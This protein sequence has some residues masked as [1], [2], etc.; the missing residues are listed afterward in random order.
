MRTELDIYVFGWYE[1]YYFILNRNR[2][3]GF[4][5]PVAILYQWEKARD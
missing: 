4:T 2:A 1:R 3:L 5:Y